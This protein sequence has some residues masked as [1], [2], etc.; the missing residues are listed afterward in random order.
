MEVL[1]RAFD[2]HGRKRISWD[3]ETVAILSAVELQLS[4]TACLKFK[5]KCV[6]MAAKRRKESHAIVPYTALK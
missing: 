3:R 5:Q 6:D 1:Q 4:K 2:D